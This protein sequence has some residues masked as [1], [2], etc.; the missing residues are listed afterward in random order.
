MYSVAGMLL[1]FGVASFVT[2]QQPVPNKPLSKEDTAEL[3]QLGAQLTAISDDVQY[4]ADRQAILDCIKRYTRGADRHDEALLRSAFWP[5]AKISYGTPLTREEFIQAVNFSMHGGRAAHQHQVT[6]QLI[7]INGNIA[8]S[9]GYVIYSSQMPRDTDADTIGQGSPG[10]AL[11]NLPTPLGSGRYLDKYERRSGEWGILVR[12]Y[13]EDVSVNMKTVDLC[14]TAC[15]G[16]WDPSDLSYLR[17][18][19]SVSEEERTRRAQLGMKPSRAP[20]TVVRR[21][22]P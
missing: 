10:R 19:Q 14:A 2:A 4:L 11:A 15:L 5:D 22:S 1:V 18:L 12:E 6:S 17:P 20:E 3:R 21:N 16:R 8:H 13:V 7:E 9:D